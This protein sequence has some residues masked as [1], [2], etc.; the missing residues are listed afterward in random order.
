MIL[1]LG[2]LDFTRILEGIQD[3]AEEIPAVV[4]F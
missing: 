4:A 3:L 2:P 1:S